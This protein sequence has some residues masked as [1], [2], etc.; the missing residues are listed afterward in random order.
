MNN[1]YTDSSGHSEQK[2]ASL[3]PLSD[4]KDKMLIDI[5]NRDS[6]PVILLNRHQYCI[7]LCRQ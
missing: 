5:N 6:S 2:T 1:R 3:R 4:E 7:L